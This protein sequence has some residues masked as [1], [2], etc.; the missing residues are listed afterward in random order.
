MLQSLCVLHP[1]NFVERPLTAGGFSAIFAV[2]IEAVFS[3]SE[4]GIM[5]HSEDSSI[6]L[7]SLSQGRVR[8]GNF[9]SEPYGSSSSD[10]LGQKG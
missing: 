6:E 9:D 2:F 7:S 1:S 8:V 5:R 3:V 10:A 4:L